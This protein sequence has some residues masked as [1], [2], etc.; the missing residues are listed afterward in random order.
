MKIRNKYSNDA[1]E[2]S[3]GGRTLTE[4]FVVKI[5]GIVLW[6]PAIYAVNGTLLFRLIYAPGK[7]PHHDRLIINCNISR[8]YA[9][10][11][12]V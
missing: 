12:N 6:F 5:H 9:Y 2:Y 3:I 4:A 8:T 1:D 11:Y 10:D 7:P